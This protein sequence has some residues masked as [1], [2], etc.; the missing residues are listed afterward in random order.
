MSATEDVREYMRKNRLSGED[1]AATSSYEVDRQ[2]VGFGFNWSYGLTQSWMV[3]VMIPLRFVTTRTRQKLQVDGNITPAMR[4]RLRQLADSELATDGFDQVP[5]QKQTWEIGDISLL[6]QVE[7]ARM[8]DWT[9]SLQQQARFPTARSR[10]VAEYISFAEDQGSINLGVSSLLD[11]QFRG[12]V[13]GFRAGY[14]AQLADTVRM[15]GPFGHGSTVDARAGRDLGDWMWGAVDGEMRV[16]RRT[17]INLE[18][19]FLTK[20]RDRYAGDVFRAEA[21]ERMGDQSDQQLHQTR[22]GLLYKIGGGGTKL[23]ERWMASVDY[24]Y[25]WLGKNS[26]EAARTSFELINYF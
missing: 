4:E 14:V 9:W 7:I 13:A 5:V 6:S 11:Y 19:S 22:L 20:A 1:V 10:S 24:T 23:G 25:P 17:G 26:A 15:R 18:H 3:G 16:G 8:D 2:E 12:G 21:Y